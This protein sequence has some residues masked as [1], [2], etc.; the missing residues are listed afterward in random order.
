MDA[1]KAELHAAAKKAF[2]QL[3]AKLSKRSKAEVERDVLLSSGK[4]NLIIRPS[5]TTSRVKYRAEAD[6]TRSTAY[7]VPEGW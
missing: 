4:Y 3:Q 6:P 1:A 7:P 5:R 2:D